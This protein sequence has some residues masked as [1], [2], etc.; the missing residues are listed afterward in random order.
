M[1]HFPPADTYESL[2]NV[3]DVSLAFNVLLYIVR[4]IHN[5]YIGM[6]LCCFK[7]LKTVKQFKDKG[8]SRHSVL[9]YG[10]GDGGGGPT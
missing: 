2:A 1:A 7:V 6:N 3:E 10:H 8:R 9:L 4:M 5:M